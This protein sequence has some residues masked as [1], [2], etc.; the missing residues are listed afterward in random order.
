MLD[1]APFVVGMCAF[2]LVHI[3]YLAA[4][5]GGDR[6]SRGWR[7]LPF[8]AWGAA[9]FPLLAPRLHAL[10][11]PVAVYAGLLLAMMWRAASLAGSVAGGA[12]AAAGAILSL[13][14]AGQLLIA[15]SAVRR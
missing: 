9:V 14:W 8:L 7:L 12:Y 6:E 5:L 4:F 11:V 3:V 13:Y 1:V 15:A 10:A 2:A